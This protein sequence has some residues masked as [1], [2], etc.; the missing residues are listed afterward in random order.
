MPATDRWK[1]VW[2]AG[3]RNGHNSWKRAERFEPAG[4]LISEVVRES[5]VLGSRSVRRGCGYACDRETARQDEKRSEPNISL[6][7]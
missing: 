4:H 2:L 5:Q 3:V 1:T 7:G 6:G